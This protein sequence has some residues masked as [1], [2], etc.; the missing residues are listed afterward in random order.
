M[1]GSRTGP[2]WPLLK[3]PRRSTPEPYHRRREDSAPLCSAARII[4]WTT[5]PL[6]HHCATRSW[7]YVTSKVDNPRRGS[8]VHGWV[9]FT[10]LLLTLNLASG[11]LAAR[12][13]TAGVLLAGT[14]SAAPASSSAPDQR[15]RPASGFSLSPGSAAPALAGATRDR[16]GMP[17]LPPGS[18]GPLCGRHRTGRRPGRSRTTARLCRAG[19]HSH[20]S[21][22]PRPNAQ[23][24]TGQL[25]PRRSSELSAQLRQQRSAVFAASSPYLPGPPRLTARQSMPP[26]A[27][28]PNRVVGN[29]GRVR[30]RRLAS[31]ALASALH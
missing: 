26:S 23:A 24:D 12:Q 10:Y 21:R 16:D 18:A 22:T 5:R 7:C 6:A 3:R 30:S 27:T 20:A 11:P 9:Y 14:N 31:R 28:P 17:I 25:L 2:P 8:V 29:A 1:P 4:A 15:S 19:I 13:N